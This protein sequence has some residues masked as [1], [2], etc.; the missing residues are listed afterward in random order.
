[1]IPILEIDAVGD[2]RTL[3]T[4]EVNLYELGL[5]G[6]VRRAS[7]VEFDEENQL[8]EVICAKTGVVV[9][10][11]KNRQSAIEKEIILF[12][13]GGQHYDNAIAH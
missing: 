2:I 11:N 4:D 12:G 8:W 5:V 1:M 3:Y 6:N 7:R 10:K 9:Y 13:P